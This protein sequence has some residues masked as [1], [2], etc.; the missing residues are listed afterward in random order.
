MRWLFCGASL[1]LVAPVSWAQQS[2]DD[3]NYYT[4]GN[5]AHSLL[6][7][8]SSDVRT[9][10]GFSLAVGR[11]DPKLTLFRKLEGELI[12][13]GYYEVTN[14]IHTSSQFPAETN[15]VFGA[16]ATA[17]YKWKLY[18][19]I[20]IYGDIGMGIQFSNHSSEDLRLANNTTPCL[21]FGLQLSWSNDTSFLIGSRVLHASNAGRTTPNPGENLLQWYVGYS[22]RH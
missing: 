7:L 21:G 8:G 5:I 18:R 10:G 4:Y 12:W 14:T 2:H 11:K 20:S 16:L 15:E 17:R 1:C 6:I 3:F 13:E 9:G 19:N 22:Y